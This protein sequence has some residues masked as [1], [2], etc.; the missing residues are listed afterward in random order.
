MTRDLTKGSPAKLILFFTIP[1]LLGNVFQQLYSMADTIIVG[2]TIGV[3]AL[4]AVGSTG[5]L[6]FLIIG[7]AQGLTAGFSV[8]TAQRFGADDLIGVRKSYAA[9]AL[10]SL[11]ITVVLTVLSVSFA[12]PILELLNTPPEI[13]EG[14]YQYISV[15]FGGIAASVL[16]NLLSN[17]IRALGDSKT[18]LLFLIIACVLN[19]GLDFLFILGFRMGVAGAAW[20]TVISQAVSGVLCLLYIKKNLPV[21]HLEFSDLQIGWPSAWQHLRLGLPMA[22]QCSI[23][24]IGAMAVQAALNTL[25]STAVAAFTAAQKIDIL[26]TQPLN[27][28]GITMATYSAQ[29]FGAGNV[30]R[31]R[32]GVRRCILMSVLFAIVGGGAVILGGSGLVRLFVGEGQDEVVR[33]SLIYLVINCS[34]YFALS[35]LFIYRNTLQ[36]LGKSGIPTVAGIMELLMRTF[37][38][39]ILASQIGFAGVCFAG[40]VAWVGALIPLTIA[41]YITIHKLMK[42]QTAQT[43]PL[44]PQCAS[45]S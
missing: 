19:I 20:A 9:S 26:I 33:L 35:L 39:I 10:L 37:A 21:L 41:Y 42:D 27:S 22:F 30:A 4:A 5:S 24:A 32:V 40:P 6:S 14:A 17:V 23:I 18:P 3:D 7:F 13:I 36:G 15:I 25:G 45:N 2:R 29:N 44:E 8:V 16:F 31:I 12:R 34:M 38:A 11:L 43:Q 1:L 28:F